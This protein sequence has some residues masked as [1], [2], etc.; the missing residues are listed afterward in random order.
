MKPRYK[1]NSINL[2]SPEVLATYLKSIK[3]DLNFNYDIAI[4]LTGYI[5]LFKS[6]TNK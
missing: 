3:K 6:K 2:E 1:P 5:I 4:G